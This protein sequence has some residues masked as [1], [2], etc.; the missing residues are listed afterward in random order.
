MAFLRSDETANSLR[1]KCYVNPYWGER[2][3]EKRK[4]KKRKERKTRLVPFGD[5]LPESF[6]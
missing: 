1:G 4:K 5:A 2:E 6:S 3:R